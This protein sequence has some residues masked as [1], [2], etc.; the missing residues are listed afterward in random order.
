MH[1]AVLTLPDAPH[2]MQL[3]VMAEETALVGLVK[4]QVNT[5]QDA[6]GIELGEET[7]PIDTPSNGANSANAQRKHLK[8]TDRPL[9]K[10]GRSFTLTLLVD[11]LWK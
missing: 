4:S 3:E 7:T 11:A 10:G 8:P 5:L 6:P 1:R 2:I 9:K